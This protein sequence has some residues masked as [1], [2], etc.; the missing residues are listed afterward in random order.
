MTEFMSEFVIN[1]LGSG[2]GSVITTYMFLKYLAPRVDSI[3]NDTDKILISVQ[4]CH[5]GKSGKKKL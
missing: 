4:S 3:K 2:T 1:A 5:L